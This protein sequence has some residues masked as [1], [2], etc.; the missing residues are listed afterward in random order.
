MAN[1]E[2]GVCGPVG[3]TLSGQS[4]KDT[5]LTFAGGVGFVVSFSLFYR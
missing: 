2:V 4:L 3:A 5:L 1:I